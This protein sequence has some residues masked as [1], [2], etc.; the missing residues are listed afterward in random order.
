MPM[1]NARQLFTKTQTD[2]VIATEKSHH[3]SEGDKEAGITTE[4]PA[5]DDGVERISEEAQA[6]VRKIEATT[7]VWSK[8]HLI[9]AYIL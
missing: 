5:S 1:F 4:K 6:G 9:A 2:D 3:D 8:S 7:L